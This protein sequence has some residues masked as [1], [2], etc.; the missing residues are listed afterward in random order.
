MIKKVFWCF[1]ILAC[2]RYTYAQSEKNYWVDSVF[3]TLNTNEKI[4][5]LFMVPV[6]PGSDAPALKDITERIKSRQ[7]G[8]VIFL[9]GSPLVQA[10]ITNQFQSAADIPLFIGQ[11]AEWGPGMSLDST[12]SFPRALVLGAIKDD[13]MIYQFGKEVGRQLK[14]IGVNL[15]FAPL[16]DVS[17]NPQNPVISYRSFGENKIKVANK[18]VAFMRGMQDQ[19]VLACAKHFPVNGI[20]VKDVLKGFPSIQPSADSVQ[21][22]PFVKLFENKITGVMPLGA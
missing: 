6:S 15:N 21:A 9:K 10:N 5:Q 3:S 20:T 14:I 17:N 13:S 18:A 12:M 2:S 4:G 19:H 22:Y 11:D 7:V 16:A 8:G 1:L